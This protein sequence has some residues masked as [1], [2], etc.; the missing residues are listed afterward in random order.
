MLDRFFK[1]GHAC[2]IGITT[3]L[4]I[5]KNKLEKKKNYLKKSTDRLS[6]NLHLPNAAPLS[7]LLANHQYD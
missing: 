7:D 2:R 6:E 5:L 1:S 3:L 4:C